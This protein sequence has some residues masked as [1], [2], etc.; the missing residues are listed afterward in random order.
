MKMEG[1]FADDPDGLKASIIWTLILKA[2][3][4]SVTSFNYKPSYFKIYVLEK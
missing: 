1:Y 3:D 4:S 2:Y